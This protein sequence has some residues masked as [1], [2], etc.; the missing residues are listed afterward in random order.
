MR[1]DA[2]GFYYFVDRI[3]DTF[4]WKGEN[5][6]TSE[7]AAALMAF[8]GVSEASVYGVAVPGTEG[9]AGMATLVAERMPDFAALRGHLARRLPPYARPLFLRLKDRIDV[10][11][12]F[13]H[14]KTELTREGFDPSMTHDTI[15]FDDQEQQAYVPLDAALYERI[16]AGK[17]RL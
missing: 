12:T 17:M 3:G 9:A 13:K 15:Y 7:V 11:A 2:G 5:V 6:A 8:P 10:T 4:R 14:K 16:D 1:R